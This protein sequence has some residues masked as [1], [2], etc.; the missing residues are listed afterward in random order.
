[1]SLALI[2]QCKECDARYL[3]QYIQTTEFQRELW[4]KTIHVAFPKKINLGEIGECRVAL[5][6]HDEQIVIANFLFSISGKIDAE[7]RALELY[8][9]QKQFLLSHLFI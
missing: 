5:P 8:K 7:K 3:Y 2:K 9:R 6:S 1:V 4:N